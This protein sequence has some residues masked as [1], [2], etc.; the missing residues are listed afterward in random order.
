MIYARYSTDFQNDRSVEDQ[1]ELCR[2]HAARLGLAVIGSDHDRGKS[3]ASTFGRPGLARIMRE[4]E[5]GSFDLLIA[6]APD[7]ISRNTRWRSRRLPRHKRGDVAVM[8]ASLLR[9]SRLRLAARETI[10]LANECAEFK[11]IRIKR[12]S[13]PPEHAR[14]NQKTPE[15]MTIEKPLYFCSR[16]FVGQ[17]LACDEHCC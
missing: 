5:A 7:R 17:F 11:H 1:V 6:E 4:A 9:R 15:R 13:L 8:E 12:Y 14:R 10:V 3:G 2:A 16:Q